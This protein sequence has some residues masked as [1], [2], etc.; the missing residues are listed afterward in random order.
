MRV[1]A[2]LELLARRLEH[3][4]ARVGAALALAD[5]GRRAAARR[6]DA[7]LARHDDWKAALRG[8]IAAGR[9]PMRLLEFDRRRSVAREAL[10]LARRELQQARRQEAELRAELARLCHR[11]RG[12]RRIAAACGREDRARRAA[13]A[14]RAAHDAWLARARG[15]RA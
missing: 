12:L 11:E 1:E 4:A 10:D 13:M 6:H 7:C 9:D 15:A 2:A 5:A 8:G 3:E 14:G